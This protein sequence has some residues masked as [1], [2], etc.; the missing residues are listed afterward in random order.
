MSQGQHGMARTDRCGYPKQEF[1]RDMSFEM[2]AGYIGIL[3]SARRLSARAFFA[4]HRATS[5]QN[6]SVPDN[7]KCVR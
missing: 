1:V 5:P 4:C 2:H 3:L 6:E 7:L